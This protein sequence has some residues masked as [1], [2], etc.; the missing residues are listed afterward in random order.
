[1][2]FVPIPTTEKALRDSSQH[3]LPFLPRI[4]GRS[5]E[6]PEEL[7]DLV[8]SGRMQI[9]I[10][11]DDQN[12]EARALLGIQIR[13]AGCELIGE[14][15]WGTG[16]GVKD[17]QHLLPQLEQYLK[18]HLKCTIIKP[19][20]RPGWKPLLKAHGYKQTHVMM[21]KPL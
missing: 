4:A 6:T 1:M 8:I 3:W 15:H 14:V 2:H 21:E 11:W 17:W 12:N 7:L 19:I 13:K 20:C 16:F 10:V 9:G 5:D 18:A